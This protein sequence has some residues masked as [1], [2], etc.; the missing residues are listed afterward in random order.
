MV[1]IARGGGKCL[2]MQEETIFTQCVTEEKPEQN[3]KH[4]SIFINSCKSSG[5]KYIQNIHMKTTSFISSS[6]LGLPLL[7]VRR[8]SPRG[9]GTGSWYSYKQGC[10]GSVCLLWF[11][12]T[13]VLIITQCSRFGGSPTSALFSC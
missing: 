7:D 12:V 9:C 4:L 11:R 3:L 5:N 8:Q 10:P 6:K 1:S 13:Q 2:A